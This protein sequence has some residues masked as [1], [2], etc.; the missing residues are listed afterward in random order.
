MLPTV[1]RFHT[2]AANSKYFD[3]RVI[4]N[5][6]FPVIPGSIFPIWLCVLPYLHAAL[7]LGAHIHVLGDGGVRARSNLDANHAAVVGIC[8]VDGIELA[9][10]VVE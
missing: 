7:L 6:K 3:A 9:R 1:L 4:P 2:L 10:D 5:S 8:V